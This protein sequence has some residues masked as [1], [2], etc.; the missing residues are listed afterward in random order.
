MRHIFNLIDSFIFI[1]SLTHMHDSF[2]TFKILAVL[3]SI[4]N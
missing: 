3:F 2:D 4:S 1:R